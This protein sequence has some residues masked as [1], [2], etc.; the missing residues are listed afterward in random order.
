MSRRSEPRLKGATTKKVATKRPVQKCVVDPRFPKGRIV[1]HPVPIELP[2]QRKLL[3]RVITHLTK[4]QLR[5]LI[6][7]AVLLVENP[8]L[9]D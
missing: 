2:E 5:A 8:D 6:R 4:G 7:Y 9:A 1:V 3:R